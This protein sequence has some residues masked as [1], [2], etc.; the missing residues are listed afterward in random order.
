M[1]FPQIAP[2]ASVL[3]ATEAKLPV[4]GRRHEGQEDRRAQKKNRN[5]ACTIV[6]QTVQEDRRAR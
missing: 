4:A 1:A 6:D 2:R 5:V 3:P